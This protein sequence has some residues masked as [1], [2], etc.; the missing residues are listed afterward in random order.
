[1]IA[2]SLIVGLS[3]LRQDRWAD[4]GGGRYNSFEET[5][6]DERPRS[7]TGTSVLH[8]H[9]LTSRTPDLTDCWWEML[10]PDSLG[11]WVECLWDILVNFWGNRGLLQSLCIS[12]PKRKREMRPRSPTGT[13]VPYTLNLEPYFSTPALR[14]GSF[15]PLFQVALYLPS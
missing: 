14:H 4:R 6:D 5:G 13:S 2:G 15:Y 7:P 11:E 9:N 3:V 10:T 12:N 1:M 8:T